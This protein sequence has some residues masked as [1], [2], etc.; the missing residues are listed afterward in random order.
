MRVWSYIKWGRRLPTLAS[1]DSLNIR[2][3]PLR[4]SDYF[5]ESFENGLDFLG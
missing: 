2:Q 5:A 4:S 3:R 1:N